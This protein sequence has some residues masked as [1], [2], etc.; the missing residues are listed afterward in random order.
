MAEGLDVIFAELGISEYQGI[1]DEQG[2]DTLATVLD[3]TESDL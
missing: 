2:F 1:F 3:I